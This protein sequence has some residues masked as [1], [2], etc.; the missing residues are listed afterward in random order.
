[1]LR[2]QGQPTAGGERRGCKAGALVRLAMRTIMPLTTLTP[3][4]S[5]QQE[6]GRHQ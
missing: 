1:M 5:P 2:Q 6:A 4:A 3:L